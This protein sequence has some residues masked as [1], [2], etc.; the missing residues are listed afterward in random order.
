MAADQEGEVLDSFVEKMRDKRF[1]LKF[2]KKTLN[3]HGRANEMDTDRLRA[4]AA[5]QKAMGI[6][7]LQET[8]LWTDRRAENCRLP[9][10]RRERLMRR[11]RRMRRL[12]KFASVHASVQTHFN[13]ERACCS[14]QNFVV[15]RAAPPAEWRQLFAA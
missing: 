7:D 12:Q 2:K 11:F 8:G 5:A 13:Q 1:S 9:F 3:W 6:P 15:N 4:Y 14:R 10:R